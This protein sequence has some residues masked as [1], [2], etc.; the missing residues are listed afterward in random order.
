MNDNQLQQLLQ[1]INT[2]QDLGKVAYFNKGAYNSETTYEINDVVTYQGSSYVSLGNNNQGNLPTNAT[3][4]SVVALKGDKGE[5]GKPFVI[6]KTYISIQEMVADY[7]NMNVNDYVMISGS[8]EDEQ[9]A[10]LWT[11]TETPAPT[12][13]WIYLADFS[14]ASG[15]TGQTPNIQIG[16]VTE[17]NEPAV[18]RRQGSTNENPIL[19]FVLKTG[20]KGDTGATGNGISQVSKTSTSGLTDTYTIEYTSGNSTTFD[21][22]NGKGITSI[23][24]TGTSGLVDTYT[25]TYNDETTST[26]TITNG[27]DG[28]VTQAQLDETNNQVAKANM[29]YNALPKV[30]DEGDNL[31]LDGTANCPMKMELKG[32]TEQTTYTGKNLFDNVYGQTEKVYTTK[33]NANSPLMN[34]NCYPINLLP[35]TQYTLKVDMNGYQKTGEWIA[36]I[37]FE[38][39]NIISLLQ[40]SSMAD[41]TTTT[42]TTD[43]TGVVYVGQRYGFTYGTTGRM[44]LF[45]QTTKIQLEEGST[46]TDYEPYVGGSPSP[47]PDFPQDVRVVTGNNSVKVEGKNLFDTTITKTAGDGRIG[48]TTLETGKKL[49]W[50][51]ASATT[52]Y[53]W[54]GYVIKDITNYVGKIVSFKTNFS[55]SAS[56]TPQYAI[57]ICDS[58]GDNR[59]SKASS[60]TS[61][62]TISFTIPSLS[63]TQTYL[64]VLL[65]ANSGGTLNPNDYVDFTNMIL[66]ID[67]EDMTYIPYQS[68]THPINLGTMELCKI[69]TYQDY[70]YKDNGNW[71]K[72]AAIDKIILDGSESW[73]TAITRNDYN[74]VVRQF[75]LEGAILSKGNSANITKSTHFGI[76]SAD[77]IFA[78]NS[79]GINCIG[80]NNSGY[81]R[82]GLDLTVSPNDTDFKAWLSL[83]N[84]T[85]YYVLESPKIIQITDTTLISQLNAIENAVSYDTQTNIV[86]ENYSEPFI[87]N[88]ECVRS[89]KDIFE[90]IGNS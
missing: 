65:Y 28:E 87:I 74:K 43:S 10:T 62:N 13:K 79:S 77:N 72:Y 54:L 58:D 68:Q 34:V 2:L 32:N 89:L 82:V 71:Y 6:E 85:V 51:G 56:N 86:Q 63:G 45:L 25:I 61:G 60:S 47:S 46:A 38:N 23:A 67:N 19:D 11:K 81:L 73:V 30:S 8:V 24:K 76:E 42:F 90:L 53:M 15:I 52:G 41:I 31:T 17:G 9:N 4:W 29:V 5:T 3:Y 1:A 14:G 83:N 26:F 40:L 50:N 69:G 57:G 64:Y 21:V 16:N 39:G 78:N 18:T 55:A 75:Y 12:Y 49:T 84:V 66:T 80:I 37:C 35:N 27:E 48:D 20:A 33:I 36:G 70:I 88:A 59:T 22:T 44:D 7:D